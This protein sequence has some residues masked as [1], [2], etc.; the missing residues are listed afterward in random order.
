[1][2]FFR[3]QPF[4]FIWLAKPAGRYLHKDHQ[5]WSPL[6]LA[7]F[8]AIN[9]CEKSLPK[10]F[11]FAGD[12]LDQWSQKEKVW[13]DRLLLDAWHPQLSQASI[14]LFHGP[15][16]TL[17]SVL[18]SFLVFFVS[19]PLALLSPQG[20]SLIHNSPCCLSLEP[21]QS[22][23]RWLPQSPASFPAFSPSPTQ[24]LFA[25][26]SSVWAGHRLIQKA[27]IWILILFIYLC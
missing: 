26:Y 10:N 12:V 13:L 17:T 6:T 27:I 4:R 2:I 16:A 15:F 14:S 23:A 21:P 11:N 1:M 8:E 5:L 25:F 20:R 3:Y 22:R 19:F 7:D 9:R 24:Q 18:S